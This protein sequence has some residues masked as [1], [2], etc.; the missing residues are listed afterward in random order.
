MQ[1]DSGTLDVLNARL[2]PLLALTAADRK[3]MD[4]VISTV[5]STYSAA[6]P[7]R[8]QTSFV[9]SEDFLRAKFEVRDWQQQGTVT[10]FEI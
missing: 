5:D 3:W 4:E 7:T 8:P 9:G 2:V 1:I 10:A 6:D